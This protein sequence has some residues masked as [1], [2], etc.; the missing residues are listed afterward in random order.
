MNQNNFDGVRI[1]LALIVVFAHVSALTAL[2]DFRF[3]ESLFDSNFAVKGFFAISGFLVTRSWF[4]SR[5]LTEYADKRLRRIYPAYAV[6]VLLC[7][8]MGLATSRLEVMEFLRDDQTFKYLFTNAIFLNFL[9]PTLPGVFESNPMP[10]MNGS[11]W[12]I[13]I[14]VMLYCCLP[15]IAFSYRKLGSTVTTIAV[16]L[17]SIAWSYFFGFVYPGGLGPELAR[18]FPGQLAYFAFG[19]Y[20]ATQPKALG[21]IKW[22]A[23]A[24]LIAL[25]AT[26]NPY[27]RLLIDPF[28]Y[29]S[30]VIFLALGTPSTLN[31]GRFGDISYGLYLYHFPIIQGL[32]HAGVFR[33]N[34][35]LGLMASVLLTTIAAWMSWHLIE[36]RLLKR[37]SHYVQASHP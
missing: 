18:Q 8:A 25:L 36:K 20:L 32:I 27:A 31:F 29:T 11:L 2:P 14:E 23:L 5:S 3:F 19:S 21:H 35:W 34:P 26:D 37:S 16:V 6:T 17:C 9:Q 10:A 30:I 4:G 22:L 33:I 24:S 12:T 28:A 13:K 7:L 15:F 1:G